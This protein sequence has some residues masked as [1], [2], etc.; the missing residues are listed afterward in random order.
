MAKGCVGYMTSG[1]TSE[2]DKMSA[3]SFMEDNLSYY[4]QMCPL[5]RVHSEYCGEPMKKEKT[6]DVTR[7]VQECLNPMQIWQNP[8]IIC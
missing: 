4:I 2:Q 6:C 5:L 7:A 8:Q 3:K 1:C